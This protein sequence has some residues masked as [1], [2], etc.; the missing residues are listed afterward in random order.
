[1]KKVLWSLLVT[2]TLALL[3][4]CPSPVQ[5]APVAPVDPDVV[6]LVNTFSGDVLEYD[7]AT[8]AF[9]SQKLA[10]TG[11]NA[12]GEAALSGRQLFVTVGDSKAGLFVANLDNLAAGFKQV[13]STAMSAQYLAFVSPNLAYVTAG[14][15]GGQG[16][17]GLYQFNPAVPDSLSLIGTTDDAAY[18]LQDVLAAS[19]GSVYL[20]DNKG[21]VLRH[22]SGTPTLGK[23][24]TSKSGTTDLLEYSLD[25][26]KNGKLD[27]GVLVG[28]TGP[29][30]GVGA[31]DF[32]PFAADFFAVTPVV[33]TAVAECSPSR[34]LDLGNGKV[35]ASGYGTTWLLTIKADKSGF[36]LAEVKDGPASFGLADLV[37]YKGVAYGIA[38]DWATVSTL[39]VFNADGTVKS[40]VDTAAGYT[41]FVE[42]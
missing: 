5:P 33:A 14:D 34:L 17:L 31:V 40:K 37:L 10:S 30:L 29:Y 1:M 11:K 27:A 38:T 39:Y 20:A 42:P 3:A 8:A 18:Y 15:W 22:T 2:A 25:Y 16:N 9:A 19:D 13:G 28:N 41:N 23:V 32:V 35:L 6:R 12:S 21:H 26:D 4:A 36:D 24:V 7:I